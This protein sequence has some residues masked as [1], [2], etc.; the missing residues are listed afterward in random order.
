MEKEQSWAKYEETYMLQ[1]D[2]EAME[3]GLFESK[4]SDNT[5]KDGN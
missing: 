2:L 4:G 5:T 3:L 1:C